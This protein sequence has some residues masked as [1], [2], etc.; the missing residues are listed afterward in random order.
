MKKKLFTVI[1]TIAMALIMFIIPCFMASFNSESTKEYLQITRTIETCSDDIDVDNIFNAYEDLTLEITKTHTIFEG[2]QKITYADLLKFDEVS[3]SVIPQEEIAIKY[4]Y[5]YIAETNDVSLTAIMVGEN[6]EPV[7]ETIYGEAFI[8]EEGNIDAYLEV[9]NEIVL[10]SEMEESGLIQ[11]CGWFSRMIK[12]AVVAAVVVAAV[13]TITVATCGAG[14]GATIAVGA[15]FGALTGGTVGGIE[16][17]K[18]TGKVDINAILAGAVAGGVAGAVTGT[19]VGLAKKAILGIKN[20]TYS[21]SKGSFSSSSKSLKYH[22]QKHG[23]DVGAETMN[24]YK[25][26]AFDV[27]KEVVKQGITP[28]KAVSGAT[29]NVFRY[30]IN[31]YYIDMIIDGSKIIVVSFG[32]K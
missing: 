17:Y 27:A 5:S 28:S 16:S 20:A 31:Q 32:L 9:E 6:N 8:N 15:A 2:V 26:K 12:N 13:A 25:R 29:A 1:S 24:Q 22:F 14:L 3:N 19:A 7:I 11:N 10:L 23:K 18:E 21:F 30:K 4:S